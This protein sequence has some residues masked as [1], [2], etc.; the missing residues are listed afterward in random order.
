[1]GECFKPILLSYI[2]NGRDLKQVF[3]SEVND[4]KDILSKFSDFKLMI[5]ERS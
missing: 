5:G 2:N 4:G 3:Q 1:M